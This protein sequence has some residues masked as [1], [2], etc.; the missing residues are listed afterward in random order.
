MDENLKTEEKLFF[1]KIMIYQD[2][3]LDS[4]TKGLG[5]H[6][7]AYVLFVSLNHLYKQRRYDP[8]IAKENHRGFML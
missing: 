5:G 4:I 1:F 7:Q 2:A 8:I 3:S 6:C